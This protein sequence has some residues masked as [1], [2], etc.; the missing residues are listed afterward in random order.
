M[1]KRMKEKSITAVQTMKRRKMDTNKPLYVSKIRNENS[2]YQEAL[3]LILVADDDKL[4][5]T[6]LCRALEKEGYQVIEASNAE[7]CL[8]AYTLFH[9]DLILLDSLMPGIDNFTCCHELREIPEH[10]RPPILMLTSLDDSE[11]L[12]QA[13]GGLCSR[14]TKKSSGCIIPS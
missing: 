5:R 2:F 4:M 9:P 11:S 8:K 1:S 12:K 10:E 13:F 3:P 14:R 7:Q 6:I